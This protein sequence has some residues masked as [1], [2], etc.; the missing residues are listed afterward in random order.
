[1]STQQLLLV[2]GA[3]LVVFWMLG[4]YNRLVALRQAIGTAWAQAEPVLRARASAVDALVETLRGPL[5]DEAATLE[6]VRAAQTQLLPLADAL[7]ARPTQAD[8]AAAL[9]RAEATLAAALTRLLSLI[10]LHPGLRQ[11]AAVAAPLATLDSALPRLA[12]ARQLYNDA[13]RAFN[14]AATQ[15]PARLVAR[16]FGLGLAGPL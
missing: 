13:V 10:E 1:M 5:A 3:A 16:L 9:A 14:E 8:R 2:A 11:D 7:Q 15:F 4:A 12:A 6:A